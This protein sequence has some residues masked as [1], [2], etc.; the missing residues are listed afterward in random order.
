MTLGIGFGLAAISYLR[1]FSPHSVLL[2][3]LKP[4]RQSLES[5]PLFVLECEAPIVF[6]TQSLFK[7]RPHLWI[8]SA[9]LRNESF[10]KGL[11]L[12]DGGGAEVLKNYEKKLKS[13]SWRLRRWLSCV[14]VAYATSRWPR[15]SDELRTYFLALPLKDKKEISAWTT[16]RSTQAFIQ[17][18]SAL[19]PVRFHFAASR[20]DPLEVRIRSLLQ[21]Y[22]WE[23]NPHILDRIPYPILRLAPPGPYFKSMLTSG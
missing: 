16:L 20:Q 12:L 21:A 22:P 19:E 9:M 5:V 13:S 17:M 18:T 8:S 3:K 2:R 23:S 11:E 6:F 4:N 10:Q 7:S 14:R 15:V 1:F